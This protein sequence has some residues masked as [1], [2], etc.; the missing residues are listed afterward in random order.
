VVWPNSGGCRLGR[1]FGTPRAK[2]LDLE[3]NHNRQNDSIWSDIALSSAATPPR[4]AQAEQSKPQKGQRRRPRNIIN[5]I[6][7]IPE[8]P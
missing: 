7:A 2:N 6:E 3:P 4:Q 1:T 8:F 5:R